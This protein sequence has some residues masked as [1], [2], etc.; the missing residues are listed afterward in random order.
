MQKK[1][2]E[3]LRKGNW[4]KNIKYS[5]DR[6]ERF[7]TENGKIKTYSNSDESH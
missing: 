2:V 1:D 3:K 7:L 5:L 4:I 6:I